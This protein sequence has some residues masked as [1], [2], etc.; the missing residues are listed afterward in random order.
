MKQLKDFS[1]WLALV[2]GLALVGGCATS[3]RNN[4]SDRPWDR[5]MPE[6]RPGYDAPEMPGSD[7]DRDSK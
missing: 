2:L 7:T 5:P 3:N 4:T 1:S 6:D